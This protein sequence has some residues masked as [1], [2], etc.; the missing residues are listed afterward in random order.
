MKNTRA[1]R[2]ETF[3][4]ISVVEFFDMLFSFFTL[5]PYSYSLIGFRSQTANISIKEVE[6][7]SNKI[8]ANIVSKHQDCNVNLASSGRQCIS[9]LKACSPG[10]LD[11][12]ATPSTS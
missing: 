6:S 1:T 7:K 5:I 8:Q 12:Q 10:Q 4:L 3:I 11:K 2:Y 9:K